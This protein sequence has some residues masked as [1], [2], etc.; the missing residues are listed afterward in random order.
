[1]KIRNGFVSNSSS[2]SFCCFGVVL[3][4]KE[5]EKYP[6][7]KWGQVLLPEDLKLHYQEGIG[8]YCEEEMLVG[9]EPTDM[10]D[11][12]TL[13]QFKE[14]IFNE[15]IKIKPELDFSEMH[16]ITDGGYEG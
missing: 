14:R 13:F 8:C 7:N 10:K 15:L 5:M 12:E 1:M 2:S 4:P 11:D 3:Q 16:W 9:L 6:K